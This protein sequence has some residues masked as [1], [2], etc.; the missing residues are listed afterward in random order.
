MCGILCAYGE[1][2][3]M[4]NF[5]IS[6]VLPHFNEIHIWHFTF[7]METPIDTYW[8]SLSEEEKARANRFYFE[9]DQKANIFSRGILRSILSHYTGIAP[10]TLHLKN[11]LHGKPFID[12]SQ[13][14]DQLC[15]NLSHT[16]QHI[17]YAFTKG[18][19]IGIDIEY[20][21]SDLDYQ[22]MAKRFFSAY[23]YQTL[24]ATPVDQQRALFYKLWTCKEAYIKAIGLSLSHSLSDFEVCISDDQA[25]TI[26]P[27]KPVPAE[28]A[29]WTLRSLT[30]IEGYIATVATNQPIHKV[31]I[32][33]RTL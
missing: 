14:P 15:F 23:E 32:T 13:N 30:P 33:T 8:N 12:P 1:N 27:I 4:P 24:M 16:H 10:N 19:E 25:T 26:H 18:S 7:T 20:I 9:K 29:Q 3:T 5:S 17:L 11:T 31:R 6:N 22:S 21:K 28:E 2:D